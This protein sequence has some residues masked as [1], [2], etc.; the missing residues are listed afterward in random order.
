MLG[1]PRGVARHLIDLDVHGVVLARR[2]ANVVTASVCGMISTENLP[3]STALTVSET[4]SSATEPFGAMK[5]HLLG[6]RRAAA[7][8]RLVSVIFSRDPTSRDA[9]DMA[10]HD[11]PPSSSP[12]FSERSRL[13]RVPRFPPPTVVSAQRLGGRLDLEPGAAFGTLALGRPP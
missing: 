9:V 11:W 1:K 7:R 6:L 5:P 12:T 10:G 3:P 2:S 4:P 8:S 13:M